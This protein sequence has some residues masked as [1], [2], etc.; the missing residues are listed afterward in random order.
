MKNSISLETVLKE[1]HNIS[2]LRISVHDV[3]F[4]EI[5]SYPKNLLPFCDYIQ[6]NPKA[7]QMCV[8]NDIK[9]FDKVKEHKKVYIYKCHFGLYEAVAPI[10]HFGVLS[11][12]LMMGQCMDDSENS[13]ETAIY[14]CKKYNFNLMKTQKELLKM[15][16]NSYE[17]LSSYITIMSICA[18]YITLMNYL[19]LSDKNL[20]DEVKKYINQNYSQKLT[21]EQL[22]KKFFCSKST[23]MNTFK[24]NYN[25]TIIE[26]INNIRL[27][28]A[29]I[30]LKSTNKPIHQIATECGFSDQNY[31]SKVFTKKYNLSPSVYRNKR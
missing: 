22:C 21:I 28:N 15:P 24:K 25:Q 1:L 19:N 16:T 11:G 26:Y 6:Q 31:F 13:K 20:S 3:N 23:L 12:Y 14:N 7:K 18:E 27:E 29:E 30:L 8:Q 5:S 10:Y 2:G 9:A 17:K 4:T